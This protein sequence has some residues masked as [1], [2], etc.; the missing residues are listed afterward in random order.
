MFALP[1][2]PS[3]T[4]NDPLGLVNDDDGDTTVLQSKALD[5]LLAKAHTELTESP[6]ASSSFFL[7]LLEDI[8]YTIHGHGSLDIRHLKTVLQGRIPATKR[9]TALSNIVQC[10]FELQAPCMPQELKSLSINDPVAHIQGTIAPSL[11]AHAALGTY[12][13]PKGNEWGT[14]GFTSWYAD[15]PRHQQAVNG[16]LDML[17]EYFQEPN[18]DEMNF[19]FHLYH[20]GD[21]PDPC[22]RDTIPD[23]SIQLVNGIVEPSNADSAGVPFVLVAANKQPGPG[24]TGTQEERLQA[25]SPWLML[26]SLLCPLL[27]DNAVVITSPLPVLGSWTGHNRTAKLQQIFPKSA[28]PLRHY[29]LADALPL[30]EAERC[31]DGLIP[32][33]LP[34]NLIREVKK[35]YAA[36]A[37]AAQISKAAGQARCIVE[38]PP[39][40]CGAFG[41]DF[42]VKMRCMMIAAGLADVSVVLSVTKD[43]EEG[44]QKLERLQAEQSTVAEIWRLLLIHDK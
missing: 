19:S 12:G 16:Y 14:P 26:C 24:P 37:G 33:L 20:S 3:L 5:A 18:T 7:A 11:L 27:P 40:G 13:K 42:G 2:H 1:F 15:A 23:F 35:L 34:E 39:W 6:A 28:R 43:R 29:I 30:D 17:F 41:G 44:I 9:E 4:T 32:D 36:F 8:A 10:A 21:M 31:A 22:Q 25:A 38:A